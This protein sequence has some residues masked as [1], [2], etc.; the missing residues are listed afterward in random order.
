MGAA[1]GS[2]SCLPDMKADPPPAGAPPPPGEM[3]EFGGA[4]W[5]HISPIPRSKEGSKSGFSG[6]TPEGGMLPLDEKIFAFLKAHG[7]PKPGAYA[8][9]GK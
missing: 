4:R 1:H 6:C 7:L 2:G 5:W 3:T 9:K 8:W